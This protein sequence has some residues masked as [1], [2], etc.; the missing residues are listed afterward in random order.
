M[1]NSDFFVL[2]LCG[3]ICELA[4]KTLVNIGVCQFFRV[5]AD[6]HFALANCSS[7]GLKAS[8]HPNEFLSKH[9][10]PAIRQSGN[11]AIRLSSGKMPL[12]LFLSSIASGGGGRF[13]SLE[14]WA[15]VR[16]IYSSGSLN[17]GTSG[18][19]SLQPREGEASV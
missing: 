17:L 16:P 7:P 2:C 19:L 13:S 18:S 6:G 5:F 15:P 10:F 1:D 9:I 3:D 8:R 14:G 12:L 4:H 11:P